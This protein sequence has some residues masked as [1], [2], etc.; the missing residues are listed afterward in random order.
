MI[1]IMDIS[2]TI[3]WKTRKRDHLSNK[4]GVK[5]TPPDAFFAAIT[6]PRDLCFEDGKKSSLE[7]VE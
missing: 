5:Y 1:T 3:V 2:S 4:E 6:G 7:L